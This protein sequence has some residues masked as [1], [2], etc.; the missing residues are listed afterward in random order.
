MERFSPA[1]LFA[2]KCCILTFC[3]VA[4]PLALAGQKQKRSVAVT[5]DDLPA[6]HGGLAEYEYVTENLLSKL[7]S[8]KVP[9]IGFVNER[10]LHTADELDRRTAL[11]KRWLDAGHELGNHTYS[12]IQIDRAAFAEY[13]EDVIRGE[14]VTKR[15]LSAAGKKLRYFRHTQLRTGPTEEY[16]KRLNEF[17][18]GRGY[19]VAPVTIDNNDYIFAM[20]YSNAKRRGDWESIRK[21]VGSY[22]DYMDRVFEHFEKLS[23]DLL[24]YEVKQ[25]LLLHANELNADHFDKLA[26]MMRNRGYKFITLTEALK[27]PAYKLPEAVSRRGLSWIHRWTLAKG[28]EMREEPSEPDW[29]A[30]LARAN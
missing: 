26:A 20:A 7:K 1:I 12:H 21:I 14:A 19:T 18:A 8:E 24:G 5:F 2:A 10:K 25:T 15:L 22:I 28:K 4:F 3:M 13:A 23:A 9:A 11:L 27:D 16:R 6:T 30:P 17:L 29:I